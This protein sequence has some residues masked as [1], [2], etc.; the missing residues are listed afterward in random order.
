MKNEYILIAEDDDEDYLMTEEAFE[1]SK[2]NR[3]LVRV[4]DGEQLLDHLFDL[5]QDGEAKPAFIILDLNMPKIDG[6]EALRRI[7]RDEVLRKF[8]IIIL[9]TSSAE[10]DVDS[11]YSIGASSYVVKPR[12]FNDF[13]NLVSTINH[14]WLDTVIR[15]N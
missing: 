6:R 12:N 9:T 4:T 11:C 15:P 14:Y 2:S 10:S 1:A 5:N 7:K 3:S 13:T 8:P